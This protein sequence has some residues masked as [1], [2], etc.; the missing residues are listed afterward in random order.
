MRLPFALRPSIPFPR[1]AYSYQT[2]SV[3]QVLTA[4]QVQQIEDNVRDHVHG[5]SSVAPQP[6]A[7]LVLIDSQSASSSAQIDFTLSSSYDDY[8]LVMRGVVPATNGTTF[9]LQVDTAG[10]G[11]QSGASDYDWIYEARSTG[12]GTAA[13]ED[14]ADTSI[15][16][17]GGGTLGL[18]NSALQQLNATLRFGNISSTSQ[19]KTFYAYGV[20]RHD[21]GGHTQYRAGGGYIGAT[22]AL[23]GIRLLMA[24]G[25]IASGAFSLYGLDN[26]S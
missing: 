14:A 20:Y 24:S 11:V 7:N 23:D 17:G 25:N 15:L 21:G 12:G 8:V 1:F 5:V 13:T 22:T 26:I 10:G 19:H 4:A 6:G 9:R 2:F 3:G 16:I 18:S